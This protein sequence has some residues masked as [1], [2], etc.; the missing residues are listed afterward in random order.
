MNRAASF[1]L[2][3]GMYWQQLP[4]GGGNHQL[5]QPAGADH[6]SQQRLE[7]VPPLT[8]DLNSFMD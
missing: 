1:P 2:P 5:Q 7:K 8:E 4:R 6:V 3:P